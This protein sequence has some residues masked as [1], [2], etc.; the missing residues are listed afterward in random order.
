MKLLTTGLD[1]GV[2][3]YSPADNIATRALQT[4]FVAAR[5]AYF[6]TGGT[7]AAAA[8]QYRTEP[9]CQNADAGLKQLTTGRNADA[10]ITFFPAFRQC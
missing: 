6:R 9:R 2:V 10:E 4:I 1:S 3:E 8:A 5:E 7:A